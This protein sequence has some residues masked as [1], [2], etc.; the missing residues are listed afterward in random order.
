MIDS[1]K[2]RKML[3][4]LASCFMSQS[5]IIEYDLTDYASLAARQS[6]NLINDSV[7]EVL[8]CVILSNTEQKAV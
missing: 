4:Q 5:D 8:L 7:Q 3:T 2:K 6:L 1:A